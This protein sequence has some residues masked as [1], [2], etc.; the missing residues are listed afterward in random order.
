MSADQIN[1]LR[2]TF[3]VALMLWDVPVSV[4]IEDDAANVT[5]EL[6][7]T[8]FEGTFYPKGDE[9]KT[10]DDCPHYITNGESVWQWIAMQLHDKLT[11]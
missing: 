8:K 9:W 2:D 6:W 3:R 7:L 10:S 5:F 1:E 11:S 4:T